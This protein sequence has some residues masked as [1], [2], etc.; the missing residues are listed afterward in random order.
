MAAGLIGTL[1][2]LAAGAALASGTAVAVAP[3][4]TPRHRALGRA[5]LAAMGVLNVTALLIYTLTGRPN[6]FHLFALVGLASVAAGWIAVRRRRPGWRTAHARS[7]LWSYV[8]LLAAAV[9][10]LL[11]RVPGLISGWTSF[12]AAV[13]AG[14]GGTFLVGALLIH[15]TVAR[16]PTGA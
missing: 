9:S 12:G 6:L 11:V 3:K 8:G 7:M 2:V 15:R 10:E 13:A 5:Y 1:H 14:T 16:L 4:G